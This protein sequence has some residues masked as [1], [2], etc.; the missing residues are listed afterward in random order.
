MK[1]IL[2]HQLSPSEAALWWLGQA[3]Y[4]LRVA[5]LAVVIDPYLSDSAGAGSP[6]FSRLYPPTIQPGELSADII[7][8]THN[9]LDHLDPDTLLHY[10][11]KE[12]T[13]FVAPWLTAKELLKLGIPEEKVVVVNAG[14]THQFGP[15]NITG[16]FALPTGADVLDTTGYQVQFANGRSIYHTS[17]TQFHPLVLDA[18]PKEP[19]VMLV[20]ING[21]W[22]NPGPEQA[23][24]FAGVVQPKFVLPNHYDTM[25]LNAENPEVFKWFCEHKGLNGRCVIAERMQPFVWQ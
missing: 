13:W 3:G 17:D 24:T 2:E 14:E 25:A 5:D 9:H 16:V 23:A 15:H 22:G 6:E 10:Q 19:N 11:K 4:V 1:T 20:P 7:I 8:I 12:D 21:K 18:A